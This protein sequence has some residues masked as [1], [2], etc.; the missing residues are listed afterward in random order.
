MGV[1]ELARRFIGSVVTNANPRLVGETVRIFDTTV[2]LLH[3][4]A[5]LMVAGIFLAGMIFVWG[6]YRLKGRADTGKASVVASVVVIVVSLALFR[7]DLAVISLLVLLFMV[8]APRIVQREDLVSIVTVA[9]GFV[10]IVSAA[11]YVFFN[12]EYQE[13]RRTFIQEKV[14]EVTDPSDRQT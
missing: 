1:F 9:F 4:S 14:A 10:I 11:A 13:L 2:A 7:I 6:V 8:F 3:L 12:D 5:F